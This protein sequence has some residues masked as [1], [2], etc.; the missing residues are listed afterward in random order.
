MSAV[1]SDPIRGERGPHAPDRSSEHFHRRVLDR[2]PTALIVVDDA[3]VIVYGNEALERIAGWS[4]AEGVGTGIFDYIHPEDQPW[5]ADAF[6]ALADRNNDDSLVTDRP[7]VP[8]HFRLVARSGEVVPV[9]VTGNGSLH[10]P[11]VDGIIYEVRPAYEREIVQRVLSGVATGGDLDEQLSLVVDLISASMID[12]DSALLRVDSGRP[13]ILVVNTEELRPVLERAVEA[14]DLGTFG[15]VLQTPEFRDIGAMGC[16]LGAELTAL[17]YCD[18]WNVNVTSVEGDASYRIIAFTAIHHIPAKGIRDR[19]SWAGELMSVI[20]LRLHNEQLLDRAAHHDALTGLPN[21]LGLRRHL[22][23]IRAECDELAILFVDLDGF[24]AVN[25][26]HGHQTGDEVLKVIARRMAATTRPDDVV[27]RLGGDEF[28]VVLAS[29]ANEPLDTMAVS[30][31]LIETIEA[32]LTIEGHTVSVSASL[33]F[34]E[35]DDDID[36]DTAI[37]AADRAMYVAK[38]AG[39]GQPRRSTSEAQ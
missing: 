9:E 6:L 27:A 31:H 23:N 10:D 21:R 30:T 11:H 29:P 38:R 39:G 37:G 17:G 22:E 2:L 1:E 13:E 3:G 12:I 24:K 25:D 26:A 32:P 18:A 14:G 16:T 4:G 33:G 7:W 19:L 36:L 35:L 8:I 5:L 28:A 20:L 34:T 15:E